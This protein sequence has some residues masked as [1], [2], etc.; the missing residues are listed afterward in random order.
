[1]FGF[2]YKIPYEKVLAATLLVAFF[3]STFDFAAIAKLISPILEA[4][5]PAL[6]ALTLFNIAA[7]FFNKQ[8]STSK[9]SIKT[10]ES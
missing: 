4:I 2:S 8:I 9:A 10:K 7:F 3:V 1:M 6:I 5:Y